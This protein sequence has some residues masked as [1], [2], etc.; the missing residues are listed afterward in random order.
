M[1]N[2]RKNKW[3]LFLIGSF[4]TTQIQF[5]GFIGISEL[6]L[7]LLAPFYLVSNWKLL[8]LHGFR[9]IIILS[10]LCLIGSFISN[11]FN[12]VSFAQAA[13]GVAAPYAIFALIVCLHNFLHANVKNVKWL[14]FGLAVSSV[15]SVFFFQY[16]ASR[17]YQGEMLEGAEATQSVVGYSLFWVS[18]LSTWLTLPLKIAYFNVPFLYVVAVGSFLPVF[19]LIQA[20]GRSGFLVNMI[21]LS[22]LIIGGQSQQQMLRIRK[23]FWLFALLGIILVFMATS[24]Y[25]YAATKGYM[26]EEQ[27]QKYEKQ[28]AYG[29]GPF[30]LLIGG[31]VES[32]VGLY[33]ALDKPIIGHGAWAI[34]KEGYYISFLDKYGTEDDYNAHYRM[35]ISGRENTIPAHSQMIVFWLWYGVAGL[36]L[37]LYIL[38]LYILI[39]RKYMAVVPQWY[40]YLALSLPSALWNIFFSPFGHRINICLLFVVCLFVKAL[41]ENRIAVYDN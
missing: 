11:Y 35:M 26:G 15:L 13:R 38:W 12:N 2:N 40:G 32:F 5:I 21:A 31:R 10:L 28:S 36:I 9:T 3:A 37:W 1:T 41:A 39:L 14:I 17:Y 8:K 30:A 34:D 4:A 18:Q 6:I 23:T 22:L 29:E 27:Y 19:S 7:F 24:I 33:A 25:K 16:G 20:G